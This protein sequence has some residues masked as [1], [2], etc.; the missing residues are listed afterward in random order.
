MGCRH[1][2]GPADARRAYR[3]CPCRSILSNGKLLASTSSDKIVR[4]WDARNGATL[5]ALEGHIISV[6]AVAFSP[7]GKRLASTSSDRTVRLWDIS[8]GAT[9]LTLEG[10]IDS[11]WAVAFSPDGKFLA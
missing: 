6:Q 3:F 7:D 5:Q 4:L 1:W 11:V 8:I 2:S 10:H 9:L